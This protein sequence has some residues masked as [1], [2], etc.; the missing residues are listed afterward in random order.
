MQ[1]Q[2]KSC[3]NAKR[4]E[5]NISALCGCELGVLQLFGFL[6]ELLLVLGFRV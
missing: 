5:G 6:G 1:P 4:P 3:S 2:E